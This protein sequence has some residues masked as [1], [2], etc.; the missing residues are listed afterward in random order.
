[1]RSKLLLTMGTCCRTVALALVFLLFFPIIIIDA[2]VTIVLDVG[3]TI[4]WMSISVS[5]L[6]HGGP[7]TRGGAAFARNDAAVSSLIKNG[8]CIG[9]T[10]G[11]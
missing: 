5:G 6:G 3:L 4:G 1:M 8:P 11:T 7:N 2:L 9:D 10:L